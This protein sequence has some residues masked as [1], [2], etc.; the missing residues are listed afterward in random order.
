MNK[1]PANPTTGAPAPTEAQIR[2]R[3]YYLWLDQG[4]PPGR[5]RE[6]W[7][8]ARAL[9]HDHARRQPPSLR[10]KQAAHS[11]DPEHHYHDPVILRDARPAVARGGAVQRIRAHRPGSKSFET[12]AMP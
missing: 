10:R 5:D 4:C 8:A 9:L 2:E 6:I 7:F 11:R 1:T 12:P 3:A